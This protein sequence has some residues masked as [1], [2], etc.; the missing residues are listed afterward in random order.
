MLVIANKLTKNP[1]KYIKSEFSSKLI[2][3]ENDFKWLYHMLPKKTTNNFDINLLFDTEIILNL[4]ISPSE[5]ISN[6][7]RLFWH[8]NKPIRVENK[9][10]NLNSELIKWKISYE[11]FF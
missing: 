9:N 8:S 1:L 10:T 6:E 4:Q 7:F 3:K 5:K 11:I 2:N